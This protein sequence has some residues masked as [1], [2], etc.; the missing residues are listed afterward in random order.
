[1]DKFIN[2]STKKQNNVSEDDP[3]VHS[4]ETIEKSK[5]YIF[6]GKFF[7]IINVED[8][9]KNKIF[10]QCQNCPKIVHGHKGSTGNFLSHIKVHLAEPSRLSHGTLKFRETRFKNC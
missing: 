3:A 7:K 10:A 1:M 5:C 4:S 8:N 6:N 9:D 2:R